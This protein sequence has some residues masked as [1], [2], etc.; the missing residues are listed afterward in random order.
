[1]TQRQPAGTVVIIEPAQCQ[2]CDNPSE[3]I[4]SWKIK[5]AEAVL[6]GSARRVLAL[7]PQLEQV[8]VV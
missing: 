6:T 4:S 8:I 7:D 5:D 2:L 3:R 1:V